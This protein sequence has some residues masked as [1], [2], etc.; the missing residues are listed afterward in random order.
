M[1]LV[2]GLFVTGALLFVFGIGFVVVGARTARQTPATTT[3]ALTPVASVKQ[4]MNGIVN[5]GATTVFDAVSTTI[6]DKG[7]EE[8][9]PQNDAEWAVIGDSAAALAE[10]GNLLMM[11]GRL[12]DRTDWITMSQAMIDASKQTLKAVEAKS[13]DGVLEAGSALNTSCDNC[14]RR[15]QR[16]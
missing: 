14:H 1:K 2:N 4:I 16:N 11:D 13:T 15:Y 8:K 5:P 12:V 9:A 3:A 6:S 10:A 7:I